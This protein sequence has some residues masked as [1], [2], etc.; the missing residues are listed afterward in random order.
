VA[1]QLASTFRNLTDLLKYWRDDASPGIA[2]DISEFEAYEALARLL[3]FSHFAIDRR[4][5]LLTR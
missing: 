5:E 3:R 2:S 1:E 4:D